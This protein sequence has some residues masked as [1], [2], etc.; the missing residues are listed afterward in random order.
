MDVALDTEG[1]EDVEGTY[2]IEWLETGKE[3]DADV[4]GRGG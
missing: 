1:I 3:K 4:C 2:Y